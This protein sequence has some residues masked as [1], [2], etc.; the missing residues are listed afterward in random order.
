MPLSS[1]IQVADQQGNLRD[2]I[3]FSISYKSSILDI[4]SVLGQVALSI[5]DDQW[6]HVKLEPLTVGDTVFNA[7]LPVFPIP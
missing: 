2:G 6:F 1:D 3:T 4:L 5:G 7:D